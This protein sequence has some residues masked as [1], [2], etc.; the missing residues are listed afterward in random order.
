ML[1]AQLS[2]DLVPPLV[3]WLL[4]ASASLFL[5]NQ[6]ITFWKEHMREQPAPADTYATKKEHEELA[7]EV[8][9]KF[10]TLATDRRRNVFE[11]HG[12][13]DALAREV[14][15]DMG[16]VHDRITELLAAFSEL[17]GA[18]QQKLKT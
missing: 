13:I 9:A 17:K 12:K 8:E 14:K 15:G 7:A 5:L 4:G 11:L 6:A 2:A 1:L 10:I 16:G 3:Q 18:V